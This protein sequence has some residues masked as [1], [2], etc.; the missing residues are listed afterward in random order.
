MKRTLTTIALL[1]AIPIFGGPALAESSGGEMRQLLDELNAKLDQAE[2]QR[3]ADPWFLRDLRDVVSKYDNPWRRPLL[4]DD[5][6]ARGPAPAPPWQVTAG[7][8][9]IDWR[10]GLRS[11]IE[12]KPAQPQ[13]HTSQGQQQKKKSGDP[14]QQLIGNLLQQA[15]GGGKK[16]SG[17]QPAQQQARQP[18]QPSFA[19]VT[20]PIPITNAFSIK[21]D[22][23]S[24]P[25]AGMPGDRFEVGTYQGA[26]AAAGYRLAYSPN[27][28]PHLELRRLSSRGTST[29]ERYD[30]AI[31]LGDG[32]VHALVWTRTP[33]GAMGV[34][35]DGRPLMSVTD[36]SF[37]DP[38]DGFAMINAG[39]DYA[40]RQ[41]RID[42][43]E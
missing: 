6:S 35:L 22:L 40:L 5:F 26:N 7:E 20:A 4:S 28:K 29:L 15:L 13:Q 38:F 9:L 10:H 17:S 32:Q 31:N 23:S 43:T 11:V 21:M 25:V 39:G 2:Q 30:G 42:G 16:N 19:A 1:W 41:I 3:L 34:S 12:N 36:R 14:T 37:N 18:Q 33:A 27:S 8:F 24:R